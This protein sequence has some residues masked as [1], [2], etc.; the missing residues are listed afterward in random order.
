[1]PIEYIK[2][3]NERYAKRGGQALQWATHE[4]APLTPLS[5]PLSR[6]RVALVSSGGVY[7]QSQPKYLDQD[8]LTWRELPK[9]VEVG[10]LRIHHIGYNH[11]GADRDINVVFPVTRMRELEARGVIGELASPCYTL[12]G[13]IYSRLRLVK[14][15]GPALAA[16]MKEAGVDACLLVPA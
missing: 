6:C 13:R 14:E 7:H 11:A 1:M 9:D 12:M 10:E 8:D 4:S 3:I 2:R 5:K 15:M 16:R